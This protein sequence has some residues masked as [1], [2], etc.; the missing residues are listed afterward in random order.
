MTSV[1]L[2]GPNN[3]WLVVLVLLVAVAVALVQRVGRRRPETPPKPSRDAAD[4]ELRS[5]AIGRLGEGLVTGVLERTGWPMLRNVIIEVDGHTVEIDHVVLTDNSI[6]VLEVKT[7]SGF[8]SAGRDP[9]VWEQGVN[10][11]VVRIVNAVRQNQWHVDAVARF[12]KDD[13][14]PVRGYVVSAGSARFSPEITGD[15]VPLKMLSTVLG[16]RGTRAD[17]AVDPA[18]SWSKLVAASVSSAARREGHMAQ[19]AG[20]KRAKGRDAVLRV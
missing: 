5:R 16:T 2:S 3:P 9:S 4:Q 6:V 20:A 14:V 12:L 19:V 17:L 11:R 13:R 8:I 18:E 7:L 15:V 10:G 1:D